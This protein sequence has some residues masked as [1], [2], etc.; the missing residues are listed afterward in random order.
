MVPCITYACQQT[1]SNGQMEWADSL[2]S[3]ISFS[4][5]ESELQINKSIMLSTDAPDQVNCY[6]YDSHEE[7]YFLAFSSDLAV[8]QNFRGILIFSL[9]CEKDSVKRKEHFLLC[10][11][12]REI[13]L[14]AAS[15]GF[16]VTDIK[17][18]R[19]EK[20]VPES[21]GERAQRF[22]YSD[23]FS[24]SATGNPSPLWYINPRL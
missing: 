21:R 13:W 6:D 15:T 11:V 3:A 17:Q 23:P 7:I 16:E 12:S 1:I 24:K 8:I 2:S 18:K 20:S 9:S 5:K 4:V 14:I 19:R 10:S 22:R